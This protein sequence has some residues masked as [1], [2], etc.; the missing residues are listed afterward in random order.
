V[1]QLP[2]LQYFSLRTC[3]FTTLSA[4]IALLAKLE[5]L[6][7]LDLYDN[8]LKTVPTEIGKLKQIKVLRLGSNELKSIPASIGEMTNLEFLDLGDNELKTL[9]ETL[10]NLPNLKHIIIG[11]NPLPKELVEKMRAEMPYTIV[12]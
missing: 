6:E 10:K 2:K 9:P 12:Q 1:A 8:M 11:G 7:E 3:R 5:T 4:K